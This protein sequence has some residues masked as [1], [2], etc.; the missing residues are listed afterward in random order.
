M[1]RIQVQVLAG[2]LQGRRLQFDQEVVR[3]G[4]EADN[5]LIL[6]G[7]YVS[8]LHGELQYVNDHWELVN[9]SPNGCEVAGKKLG[10]K[11]RPLQDR[12][13]VGVGGQPLFDV[14]IEAA[15]AAA[16]PE[17]DAE[18]VAAETPRH[19]ISGRSKTWIGIGVWF[20]LCVV[21]ML[22]GLSLNEKKEDTT[23]TAPELTNEQIEQDIK[24][25]P[26]NLAV[27]ERAAAEHLTRARELFNRLDSA[28]DALYQC[29]DNFQR[30]L[31]HSGKPMF[32]D[33]FDQRCYLDVRDRLLAEVRQRYSHAYD[34]M[35]SRDFLAAEAAFRK[36]QD[37]YPRTDGVVYRNCDRQRNV[38]AHSVKKRKLMQRPA[39]GSRQFAD[40][41]VSLPLRPGQPTVFFP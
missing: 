18:P 36:L 4:R 39:G 5:D 40:A 30:A 9:Q 8:R 15:P 11:P 19:Q 14:L 1:P 33:G 21:G 26:S 10:K 38:I 20:G 3:F 41:V 24:R 32:D 6:A 35:R 28:S 25:V 31:I 27:D 13:R 12:D 2:P 16:S 23:P 34:L 7:Q 17:A 29:Y 22:V 37:F